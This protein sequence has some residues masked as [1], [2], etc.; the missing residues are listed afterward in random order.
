MIITDLRGN[1]IIYSPNDEEKI[2]NKF[3][4]YKKKY[5]HIKKYLNISVD[6]DILIISDNIGYLY[7]LSLNTGKIIWAQNYK[8]HFRSNLKI[9]KNKIIA[10]NQNN[11]LYFI[12]KED[13]SVIR[14]IPTEEVIVSNQFI[15]N[16]SLTKNSTL[17]LNTYG[18]LYSISMIK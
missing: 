14:L 12:N 4:F 2:I 16:I 7:A 1:I 18:T 5:K 11:N 3:N 15:N 9:F 17:F 6:N 8:I 10:A 13:G